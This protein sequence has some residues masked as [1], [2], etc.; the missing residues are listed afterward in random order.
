[1]KKLVLMIAGLSVTAAAVAGEAVVLKDTRSGTSVGGA[2]ASG[3]L[4]TRTGQTCRSTE[5]KRSSADSNK[6]ALPIVVTREFPCDARGKPISGNVNEVTI[7][8]GTSK[9]TR[10]TTVQQ[11]TKGTGNVNSVVIE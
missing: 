11:T 7:R 10:G 2:P 4:L 6:V 5:Y 9:S 1:M 3:V 8:D